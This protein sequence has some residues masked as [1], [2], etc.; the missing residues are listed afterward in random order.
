MTTRSGTSAYH[1]FASE[2]YTYQGLFARGEY[3]IPKVTR[4]APFHTN[5]LSFGVGGPV[6]PN[7]KFFFFVGYESYLSLTSN[8]LRSRPMKIPP[9]YPSPRQHSPT[10]PKCCF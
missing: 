9:S 8:G 2:Y 7:H 10:R 6:I 3:D 5:N 4:V 1:G